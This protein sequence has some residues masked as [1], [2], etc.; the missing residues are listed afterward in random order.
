MEASERSAESSLFS[1]GSSW[2]LD[3]DEDGEGDDISH[4]G[5]FP[6]QKSRSLSFSEHQQQQMD[7][8]YVESIHAHPQATAAASTNVP[9]EQERQIL[10]LMLLAQ[11]C[12]LHDPTPRTFT[13][14]VLELFERGILDRQSI[15][16][17][18]ELGLVPS[19]N[20]AAKLLTA[21]PSTTSPSSPTKT[22]GQL[23][24]NPVVRQRSL[25]VSAIR[26]TLEQQENL[27][28]PLSQSTAQQS[29]TPVAGTSR[30]AKASWSAE[31][32]PLSLSRY[33]R[34][35]DQVRLLSSGS[36]GEVFQATNKTDGQD[37][38]VKRVPFHASGYS[39]DS[40]QQ[41]TREV[42]CLA[43]C[44]H[45]HVVRFYTSWLEPSWMTGTGGKAS[46]IPTPNQTKMLT[47]GRASSDKDGDCKDKEDN[48]DDLLGYFRNPGS[49]K[50]SWRRRRFSFDN[51]DRSVNWKP[52]EAELSDEESEDDSYFPYNND[53][54]DIFDRSV[55]V[56]QNTTRDDS[57]IYD[58]FGR[59]RAKK[60]PAK[61]QPAYRYQIC[62]FIQMQLCNPSTLADWIRARNRQMM[63]S[64]L[65]ERIRPALQIFE[66]IC[67]GL[68]HVHHKEIVHR[69][70][71]PANIFASKDGSTFL[72]G[73]FGLSKL[74]QINSKNDLAGK[75][76]NEDRLLLMYQPSEDTVA[77]EDCKEA[78][79][80]PSWIDP[81]TAGVG[82]ASYA[83]PE[84]VTSRSYGKEA[85]IFSLGLILLE[86]LCC[87]STEHERLQTFHD[88]RY[89]RD[90]PDAIKQI[91]A[92][93][94]TILQCTD[95]CP[96]NR[97]TADSLRKFALLSLSADSSLGSFTDANDEDSEVQQLKLQLAEKQKEVNE[98]KL[99]LADRDQTIED[100][101]QQI[102]SLRVA[103]I[104]SRSAS[105]H[106]SGHQ[107]RPGQGCQD[108][109]GD[110]SSSTSEDE[111]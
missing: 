30:S 97:P 83:S 81:Q 7:S 75:N 57:Y 12:A 104:E 37:Y 110:C 95:K 21:G 65:E 74:L 20:T 58:L 38:A 103:A 92:L 85:D 42:Q 99:L 102:S 94:N 17:L 55:P 47:N 76:L 96:G 15:H 4:D 18:F 93:A 34:E 73:D 14:H 89:R 24:A 98:L 26:S 45:P 70:L 66:Q 90:L 62:L 28:Q 78:S 64:T 27:G 11:V 84:Q 56:D 25:E 82:T 72:I 39:N 91:P 105:F 53:E 51:S 60:K 61:Q 49:R 59:G 106:P 13:V 6:S 1:R 40:V 3:E 46:V 100:L 32:H 41:V 43:A 68:A 35:F 79:E 71:K 48:S 80:E 22:G 23:M 77:E 36:F 8:D 109:G 87:F 52:T 69:D 19:L 67:S 33:Q 111:L 16:F 107:V 101:T 50:P 9:T 44:D 63:N 5:S 2:K 31:H 88:C 10:L 86:L 108:S 54:S 29:T